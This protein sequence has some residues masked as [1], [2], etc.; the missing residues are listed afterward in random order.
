MSNSKS[1]I[2]YKFQE[3]ANQLKFVLVLLFLCRNRKEEEKEHK[4]LA[5]ITKK[6]DISLLMRILIY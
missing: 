4:I 1:N 2:S 5:F 3:H 6:H